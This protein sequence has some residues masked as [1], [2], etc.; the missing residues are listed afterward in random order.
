MA[1]SQRPSST[2]MLNAGLKADAD[3]ESS[4]LIVRGTAVRSVLSGLALLL[5]P[6]LA[7]FGKAI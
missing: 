4:W 3:L 5:F 7:I 2:M 1:S 6:Y